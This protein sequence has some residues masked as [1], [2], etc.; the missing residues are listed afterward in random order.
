MERLESASELISRIER[1]ELSGRKAIE[2]LAA[3]RQFV[4]HGSKDRIEELEPRQAL[5]EGL[6]DGLPAVF[7]ASDDAYDLA[8]FMALVG[9]GGRTAFSTQGVRDGHFDF[10]ADAAALQYAQSPGT[11]GFVHVLPKNEFV[12]DTEF[13]YRCDHSIKPRLIV[14]VSSADIPTMIT[15]M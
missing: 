2:A 13:Q 1:G 7:A 12:R 4:F 11:E 3:T 8:I 14:R 10:Q 9:P 5:N 15:K 6:P